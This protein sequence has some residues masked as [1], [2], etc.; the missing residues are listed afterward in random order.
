MP[1]VSAFSTSSGSGRANTHVLADVLIVLGLVVVASIALWATPQFAGNLPQDAPDYAIP[2]VNLLERG[3][4]VVTAYGHD[5]PPCHPPGMPLLLLPAYMLFGHLLGNGI[6]AVLFCSIATVALTYAIGVK[7]GGRVCGCAAALFLI[8]NYGFWQ[9]SRKIMSEAPSVFLATA[10]LALALTIR[11]RKRPGLISLAIGGILGFAITIRNDN[12]LLLVPAVVLLMWDAAWPERLRRVGLCLIGIAPF[13]AGLAVY[14]QVTFGRPWLTGLQYWG[15]AGGAKEPRPLFS[16]GYVT[17]SG[18]MRL[19]HETEAAPGLIEGNGVFYGES[20]LSEADDTRIFSHPVHWQ[21]PDRDLYQMLALLRTALGVVGLVACCVG[22]RTNTLRRRFALWLI[23]VTFVHVS[24]YCLHFNQDERYLIR[25]VPAFCLANGIGVAFLLTRWSAKGA[26]AAV[27]VL[28]IAL[29]AK[30][31]LWNGQLGFDVGEQ[32]DV[33]ATLTSV[34]GLMEK[35]A[36]VVSNFNRFCLDAYVIHG[37]DRTA[38]PLVQSPSDYVYVGGDSTPTPLSPFSASD[39]PERLREVLRSGR[40]VYWL[41][42][43]PWQK[44]PALGL[45]TL[46]RSFHLVALAGAR[47]RDGTEP[48]FFGRVY[49]LPQQH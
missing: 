26:R 5:Y 35:N 14:D 46:A 12:A 4:L 48:P 29:I 25:L 1:P 6:Y 7:L 31:V 40:P 20:L 34:A 17:K 36:V 15:I 18:F 27:A 10:V 42:D 9:F 43:T 41:I 19:N 28:V 16:L 44:R 37:T 45:D 24:F 49:D 11:D 38:V 13:L 23:V 21:L 32:R 33:Y 8:A 30:L 47:M 3:R 39:N 2:A 22:W